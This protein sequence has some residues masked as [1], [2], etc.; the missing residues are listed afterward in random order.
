MKKFTQLLLLCIAATLLFA[1]ASFA[2]AKFPVRKID[3]VVPFGP[4]S[5]T[6]TT[7][8]A[9]APSLQKVLGVP[10]VVQNQAGSGGLRGM[11]YA[12]KQ[13]AD[14]YTLFMHTPTHIIAQVSNLSK[15]KLTENFDPLVGL[16]QDS[17]LV[18]TSAKGR[19]KVWKDVVD[20]ARQNPGKVTVA[21][22]S[23][24]GIDAVSMRMI[25]KGAG[26]DITFVP[27]GSGA[28]ATSAILGG[29]V[30]LANEG[31]AEAYDMIQGGELRALIVSSDKRLADLPDVPTTHDEGINVT[32]GPWRALAVP[33]GTPADIV[34]I[35]EDAL[36][37]AFN[38]E[39]FQTWRKR[40][41][42]DQRPGWRRSQELG[43]KWKED[44]EFF[45]NAFRE[46]GL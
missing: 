2:A 3:I 30:D 27:F 45:T 44:I 5:G 25:A 8:R 1:S 36:E 41:M 12:A 23:P 26:I 20:F 31:P 16:V 46:L 11:E 19:F 35:L 7:M 34:K 37:K 9:L 17:V 42:L 28:E 39:E 40:V 32:T 13:P 6:D 43:Q 14:G 29:H 38:S 22:M 33:K 21:G 10:I 18:T 24:K 15:V 4:G